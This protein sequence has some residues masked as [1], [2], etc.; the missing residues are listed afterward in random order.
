[1]S[2]ITSEEL[3]ELSAQINEIISSN[4]PVSISFLPREEAIAFLR[5]KEYQTKYLDMVP[6]SVQNFRIIS[7]DDYDFA[8]CAGTHVRNTSEI[9]QISL[10]KTENKGKL[11]ERIY[12]TIKKL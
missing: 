1:M 4:M 2:K 6:K 3:K 7:I 11:R 10:E 9:G 12:Y 8:A 5:E